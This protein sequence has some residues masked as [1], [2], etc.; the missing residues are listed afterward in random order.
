[1]F[2][3][4]IIAT[5]WQLV[6]NSEDS[7]LSK[8]KAILDEREHSSDEKLSMKMDEVNKKGRHEGWSIW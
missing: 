6:T 5:L 7:I 1:M 4:S 3:K 8:M 2:N